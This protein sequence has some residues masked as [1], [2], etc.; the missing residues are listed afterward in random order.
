M[1]SSKNDVCK[2]IKAVLSIKAKFMINSI[3]GM[4]TIISYSHMINDH[5]PQTCAKTVSL[6]IHVSKTRG[7]CIRQKVPSDKQRLWLGKSAQYT[8]E[9]S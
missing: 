6:D 9:V 4:V 8:I 3:F 2:L 1:A 5:K 7:W